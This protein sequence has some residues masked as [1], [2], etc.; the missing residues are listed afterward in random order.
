MVARPRALQTEHSNIQYTH[1]HIPHAQSGHGGG[2][3]SKLDV[4]KRAMAVVDAT[5]L[6]LSSRTPS[7]C[8]GHVEAPALPYRGAR[9]PQ[10]VPQDP[11]YD[12]GAWGGRQDGLQLGQAPI[13]GQK[14][15]CAP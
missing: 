11:R 15:M 7:Q 3:V 13:L 14:C 10:G 9:S 5:Q 2:Y 4:L 8:W 6:V 12:D 1:G